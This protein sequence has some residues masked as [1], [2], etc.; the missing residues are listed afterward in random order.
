VKKTY[1]VTGMSC[2][3]CVAN[4]E[5]AVKKVEGI[6]KV[7]VNLIEEMM[8]VEF[9]ENVTG[10][11]KIISAV[12]KAG[13]GAVANASSEESNNA[14]E[15]CNITCDCSG[16]N[17]SNESTGKGGE[18]NN[19]NSAG[20]GQLAGLIAS[21]ILMVILMIIAMF[22][23]WDAATNALTQF[24]LVIPVI[25][26]NRRF[27][28][29]AFKALRNGGTNMDVL[30]SLGSICSLGYSL[31]GLYN[32]LIS[33]EN[34][35]SEHAMH[36]SH[37]LYFDST[38]MILTL[39]S[40]GKFL[41]SRSKGKTKDA[42]NSLLDIVPKKIVRIKTNADGSE[43]EETIS[44]SEVRKGDIILISK[45]EAAS[46]DGRVVFGNA[47][48]DESAITGESE[49]VK[50]SVGDEVISAS[51]VMDGYV[52]VQAEAVGE[53]ST[54]R[55]IVRMTRE[56]GATKA[57]IARL[58]DKIASIF[59][60]AI[61]AIAAITFVVWII[62]SK[63]FT[64]AF[65]NAISV[66]VIS[67]PCAL[68]LATPVAITVGMG[69]GAKRGILFKSAES[70]ERLKSVEVAV[71]DKTGTI[72]EGTVSVEGEVRK[73]TIRKTSRIAMDCL[74]GLGIKT[75]MLSGDK[76]DKA[77][78]IA[79]E[80]GV[81][82]VKYELKPEDKARIVNELKAEGK[83][84]LMVGDGI[85]DAPA[86]ASAEVGMAMGAGKDIAIDSADVVLMHSDLLDVV[87]AIRLSK[88]TLL[89]IKENLFWAFFYNILMIPVAA[90]VAYPLFGIKLNP[91]IGAACMSLSSICVC[92]NA[93]RLMSFNID[94]DI[95]RYT[96][97][98]AAN[99]VIDEIDNSVENKEI[100]NNE[101]A[102]EDKEAVMISF[103]V[104]GMMCEHCKGR[105][106]N[107]LKEISGV[108]NAV[109]DLEKKSVTVEADASV[110][111]QALKDAVVAAGYKV[112]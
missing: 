31:Y 40:V 95:E 109:A 58:A 10:D 3:N 30:V 24:I 32:I 6:K 14:G 52:R 45:G 97:K 28:I 50:K 37:N 60:P 106:E 101:M 92:L 80:A 64:L 20:N 42:I 22:V 68:G 89:N 86:L 66:L 13:Y 84:V 104:E 88:S 78:A 110:S 25:I 82:E 2:A 8:L 100:N 47:V 51:M 102:K 12:K 53:E 62:I 11:E 46:V 29:N 43:T 55:K 91:M 107:A 21:V 41:E 67:C 39:V 44:Q 4:V 27:F 69:M 35:D 72:T 63:D 105:V 56:A 108:T 76:K 75:M 70:L 38:G 77:L 99:N 36:L 81:D 79:K 5:R 17:N 65:S 19:R 93:I 59:V 90:G 48:F 94:K 7:D 103:G 1:T 34:G 33:L 98:K 15:S 112:I 111:E 73:D 9:D 85:N 83:K 18:S 87:R 26:I 49:A 61:L 23:K 16:A 54:L 74:K 57:P 71:F 96:K